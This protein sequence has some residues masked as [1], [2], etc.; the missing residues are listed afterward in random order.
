MEK[1][2]VYQTIAG[3]TREAGTMLPKSPEDIA[4]FIESGNAIVAWNGNGRPSGF[5]AITF[6]WPGGWKELGALIVE[7]GHR[8]KGLGHRLVCELV[9]KAKE[10]YPDSHFFA[11]C[12]DRSLKLFLENGGE[13]IDDP[14]LLPK[15]VWGE[16]VN[17]PMRVVAMQTN[18]LCCDTPVMMK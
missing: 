6:D 12:N 17:C 8:E 2:K 14:D 16:C 9:D 5:A 1:E 18:K 15:E 11:L 3:W 13:I 7:P 4:E 10:K